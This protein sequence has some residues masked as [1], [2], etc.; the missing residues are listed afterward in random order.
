[1]G[2]TL[3]GW[4]WLCLLQCGQIERR[5]TMRSGKE[6]TNPGER[7]DPKASDRQNQVGT[8][9]PQPA[10]RE[11]IV[12]SPGDEQQASPTE[13]DSTDCGSKGPTPVE[14]KREPYKKLTPEEKDRVLG[15]VKQW[16]DGG[17]SSP[18][19]EDSM[20][21]LDWSLF[22]WR[23]FP[24]HAEDT[25]FRNPPEFIS[26]AFSTLDAYAT[27]MLA[28]HFPP[29]PLGTLAFT[30][31]LKQNKLD[32]RLRLEFVTVPE[33]GNIRPGT[34]MLELLNSFPEILRAKGL[35]AES[36]SYLEGEGCPMQLAYPGQM[37]VEVSPYLRDRPLDLWPEVTLSITPTQELVLRAQTLLEFLRDSASL[38]G[39]P[40]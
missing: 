39:D 27:A 9:E 22:V 38:E 20:I 11:C 19:I 31:R 40:N 34:A 24:K 17:F 4:G 28:A 18:K 5:G 12:Q 7:L 29:I 35:K 15:A 14:Y 6:S 30:C 16:L 32:S 1:M 36:V 37:V 13:R 3:A 25:S 26:F 10:Q 8:N 33:R 21:G 2:F 23:A